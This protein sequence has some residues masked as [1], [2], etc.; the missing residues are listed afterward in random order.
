[1]HD[2]FIL[3]ILNLNTEAPCDNVQAIMDITASLQRLSVTLR[4][5]VAQNWN[6]KANSFIE[7]NDE[8]E[9]VK[10]VVEECFAKIVRFSSRKLPKMFAGQ[11]E[12]LHL[13]AV[14][15][16]CILDSIRRT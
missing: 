13:C 8:N 4:K 1:M 7:R 15:A 14:G 5:S 10:N 12:K 11:F 9:D 2:P 3:H 16:S 6:T